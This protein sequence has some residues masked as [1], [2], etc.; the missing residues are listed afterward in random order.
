MSRA[1]TRRINTIVSDKHWNLLSELQPEFGSQRKILEMAIEELYTTRRVL[2]TPEEKLHEDLSRTSKACLFHTDVADALVRG[3]PEEILARGLPEYFMTYVL[4]KP[5]EKC[6]VDEVVRAFVLLLR[7]VRIFTK[8]DHEFDGVK[9]IHA[10]S[11][12]HDYC[13]EYGKVFFADP[14]QRLCEKKGAPIIVDVQDLYAEA[15]IESL[16]RDDRLRS[17]NLN[18]IA[19]FP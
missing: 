8:V 7:A 2:L 18:R 17:I 16:A 14:L 6:E 19:S 12:H 15:K 11:V 1:R 10:V 9:R 5:F 13:S 4:K 3:K